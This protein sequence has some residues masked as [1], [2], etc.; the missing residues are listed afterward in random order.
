MN[1]ALD[2]SL[3]LDPDWIRVLLQLGAFLL[4]AAVFWW[5][6]TRALHRFVATQSQLVAAVAGAQTAIGT[7]VTAVAKLE[8]IQTEREKDQAKLEGKVEQTNTTM[9][10]VIAT[11]QQV[12]GSIDALW[13]ALQRIHPEAIPPRISDVQD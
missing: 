9:V 8:A 12:S 11:L 1:A 4:T 3:H 5:R 6:V 7:L 13:R 2:G 10:R